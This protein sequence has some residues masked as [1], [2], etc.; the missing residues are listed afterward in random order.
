MW[1]MGV[2]VCEEDRFIYRLI[3][4]ENRINKEGESDER[5]NRFERW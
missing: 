4:N 3:I 2:I 5:I 1:K